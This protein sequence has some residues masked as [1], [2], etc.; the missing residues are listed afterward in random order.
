MPKLDLTPIQKEL[1]AEIPTLAEFSEFFMEGYVKS[2]NKY[3]ERVSKQQ[4]LKGYLIPIFGHMKLNEITNAH[5]DI[6]VSR[7]T[8]AGAAPK[9]VNNRLAVLSKVLKYAQQREIIKVVPKW[10]PM[11]APSPNVKF[12]TR[13]EAGALLEAAAEAG[14]IWGGMVAVGLFAGLRSGEIRALEWGDVD[15]KTGMLHVRRAEWRR[16]VSEPKSAAGRRSV[17]VNVELRH[18]LTRIK[19]IGDLIFSLPGREKV[20]LAHE[21]SRNR[22]R[23]FAARAGIDKDRAGWHVLRHTFASWMVMRGVPIRTVQGL[24]GHA[25]L[26]MTLRYSHLAPEAKS[27]ATN[28]LDGLFPSSKS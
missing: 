1:F 3:S 14:P 27:E 18:Y 4:I 10:E 24:L 2:R 17:S 5:I 9:T 15:F 28:V 23:S 8:Q 12:L 13:Q 7:L 25:T 19:P 6:F 11:K 16:V 22:L 26:Q 21:T 20:I